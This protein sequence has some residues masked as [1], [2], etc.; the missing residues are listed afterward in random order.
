MNTLL[1]ILLTINI[2]VPVV[3]IDPYMISLLR[4]NEEQKREV[5]I[6]DETLSQVGEN[7]ACDMR[8][9]NY[10]SHVSPEGIGPN[11]RVRN[12]GIILPTWYSFDS[13]ANQIE[14]IGIANT[15][16]EMYEIWINSSAH[17]DHVLG[18][19]PFFATQ[20]IVGYGVCGRY[21][22]FLSYQKE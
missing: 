19:H 9:R 14:S 13:D 20:T 12:A 2:Y 10:F 8:D 7:H 1:V 4:S 16:D 18:L 21:H 22:V 5:M 11:L 3:F 17:K 15:V 6:Y